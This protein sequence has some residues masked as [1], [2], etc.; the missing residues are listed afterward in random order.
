MSGTGTAVRLFTRSFAVV[1]LLAAT[2][3]ATAQVAATQQPQIRTEGQV[4]PTQQREL[5]DAYAL[6]VRGGGGPSKAVCSSTD[7]LEACAC[8]EDAC[9]AGATTCGCITVTP[10]PSAN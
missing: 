7:N 5:K 6:F 1:L 10:P 2:G 4:T 9:I 8:G 3:A